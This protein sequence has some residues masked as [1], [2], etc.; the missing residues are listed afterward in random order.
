MLSW[1]DAKIVS[2]KRDHDKGLCACQFSVILNRNKVPKSFLNCASDKVASEVVGVDRIAIFQKLHCEPFEDGDHHWTSSEDWTAFKRSKLLTGSLSSEVSWLIVYSILKG[3]EFDIKLVRNRIVYQI[4]N[5]AEWYSRA[6]DTQFDSDSE[7]ISLI[8]EHNI[9]ILSFQKSNETLKP[10]VETISHVDIKELTASQTWKENLGYQQINYESDVEILYDYVNLRRSK[11]RKVLPERFTSYS[12]PNFNRVSNKKV[13]HDSHVVDESTAMI[14]SM[15]MDEEPC[16]VEFPHTTNGEVN[17][18]NLLEWLPT[19]Q[20]DRCL[21]QEAVHDQPGEL[22]GVSRTEYPSDGVAIQ[23]LPESSAIMEVEDTSDSDSSERSFSDEIDDSSDYEF[24][25]EI[26]DCEF[27][28]ESLPFKTKHEGSHSQAI[29]GNGT[30]SSHKNHK[31]YSYLNK[32]K[33]SKR[34]KQLGADEC[35]QLIEKFM[36]N[37]EPEMGSQSQ[38]DFKWTADPAAR[39]VEEFIDFKW[40]PDAEIETETD[41]HE[42]LWKEMENSLAMLAFLEQKQVKFFLMC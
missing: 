32:R 6:A 12:D 10:K 11:R 40:S 9:K 20:V 17:M 41:E 25:D 5:Y 8:S 26:S 4:I 42:D 22:S 37:T 24:M 31:Q 23:T 3:M 1:V 36:G 19:T 39:F 33:Y 14:A 34:K 16:Q 35:K 28:Q 21:S 27:F 15:L 30:P 13:A 29:S 38:P 2:I 7:G 18:D